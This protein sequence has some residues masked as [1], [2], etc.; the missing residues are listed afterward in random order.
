MNE[1]YFMQ[2]SYDLHTNELNTNF[3][4]SI[5][6]MFGGRHIHITVTEYD[7]EF[8]KRSQ[9]LQ[10]RLDEYKKNDMKNCSI[11]DKDFWTDTRKR[12][13]DRHQKAV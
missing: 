4:E 3:L 11:L 12:L 9:E 7:S 13:I 1:E 5:K 8:D 10:T 6:N 2:A